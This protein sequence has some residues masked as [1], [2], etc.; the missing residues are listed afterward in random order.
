MPKLDSNNKLIP[1]VMYVG[2]VYDEGKVRKMINAYPVVC[3]YDAGGT[4]L[5]A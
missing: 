5:W 4:L 1:S 2:E 3:A